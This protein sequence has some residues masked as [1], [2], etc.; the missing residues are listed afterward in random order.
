M[1]L[2][3]I[4]FKLHVILQLGEI[5]EGQ[6]F[7]TIYKIKKTRHNFVKMLT[8]IVLKTVISHNFCFHPQILLQ[9]YA[10]NNL[11]TSVCFSIGGN[12]SVGWSVK[13]L[14]EG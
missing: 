13:D 12:T 9:N 8:P 7:Y 10:T 2:N 14:R 4:F 3:A 11:L 1:L 6:N 5:P